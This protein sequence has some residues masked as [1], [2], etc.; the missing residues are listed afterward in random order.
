MKY[1]FYAGLLLFICTNFLSCSKTD[2]CP[3]PQSLTISNN[4][5]IIEGWPLR[6]ESNMQSILYLYKWSGPNGWKKEYI[7]YASDAYLQFIEDLPAAGAGE[8]KL[9]LVGTDGCV[10][11]EG[12]TVV[13]VVKPTTPPCNI[14][15]NSSTSSVAGVG[16]YS[17]VYRNF[18]A[19]SGFFTISGRETVPGDNMLVVFKGDVL[20]I[21]GT[22]K[23]EGYFPTVPGRAGLY[24]NSFGVEFVSLPNQMVYVNKVNN[25][26]E[27]SFCSVQFT[28]PLSPSNP[29]TISGRIVEP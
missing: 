19:S 3:A 9:Q 10:E 26:I 11:Y 18:S 2:N 29:I 14:A 16:D 4:G 21:P 24:I 5:P 20:P 23:T 12:T 15:A 17:F 25:K 7:I 6:L 28:N 8:Y 27:V 22:Y 1:F 13:E